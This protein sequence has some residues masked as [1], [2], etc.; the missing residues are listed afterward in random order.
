MGSVN[1]SLTRE[2]YNFLRMLKGKNRSFSDVVL[3]FKNSKSNREIIIG[4]AKG[5]RNLEGIDWEDKEKRMKK[6]R[7][8][9]DNRLKEIKKYRGVDD[10]S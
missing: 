9:F 7:E 8:G 3:E 4:L 2:A 6:F 10:S 1:I 5:E